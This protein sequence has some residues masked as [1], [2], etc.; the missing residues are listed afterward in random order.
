MWTGQL[1]I[2]S[3]HLT[4]L[5]QM[6]SHFICPF[7]HLLLSVLFLLCTAFLM[8]R[9]ICQKLTTFGN[10]SSRVG[11]PLVQF[12]LRIT[13]NLIIWIEFMVIPRVEWHQLQVFPMSDVILLHQ[14]WILISFSPA[15]WWSIDRK[16]EA[17]MA[18]PLFPPGTW[19]QY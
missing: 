8:S 6:H 12:T 4:L 5:D 16:W 17:E 7:L 1:Q 18:D 3:S 11:V 9:S 13:G 10:H 2:T 15:S 14:L 19:H